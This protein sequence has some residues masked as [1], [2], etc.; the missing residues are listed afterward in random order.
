MVAGARFN[1]NPNS[2]EQA[3]KAHLLQMRGCSSASSLPG[4]SPFASWDPTCEINDS[5]LAAVVQL[6]SMEDEVEV[7]CVLAPGYRLPQEI[8]LNLPSKQADVT[9]ESVRML[10]DSLAHCN[11]ATA[12]QVLAVCSC[13]SVRVACALAQCLRR[14]AT[15]WRSVLLPG[16][17]IATD[18]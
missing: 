7:D 12:I 1:P 5:L 9:A 13:Y 18:I 4:S 8:C 15:S 10:Y 17:G 11:A 2:K 6:L 3:G 14:I 16:T